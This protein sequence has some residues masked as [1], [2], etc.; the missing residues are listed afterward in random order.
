VAAGVRPALRLPGAARRYTVPVRTA[1]D[2]PTSFVG[3]VLGLGLGLLSPS[4]HAE[5]VRFHAQSGV[6]HAVSAPQ[7]DE[8]GWGAVGDIAIELPVA[9]VLGIEAKVGALWL[10]DGDGPQN[11]VFADRGASSAIDAMGG[12]RL[13]KGAT[14]P[15]ADLNAGLVRTGGVNRFGLDSHVGVDF[16][17]DDKRTWSLGPALG[18]LQVVEPD[19]S[20]RPEDARVL[21]LGVHVSFGAR[22]E[23]QVAPPPAPPPPPPPAAPAPPPPDAPPTLV[24]RDH[25]GIPDGEDACPDVPGVKTEDPHTNGCPAASAS[26]RMEGDRILLDDVIHFDLDSPRVGHVSVPL[27]KKVAEFITANASVLEIEIAGHAD[28]RGSEEHNLVLSR[29]RA[30][31]VRALLHRFGVDLARM[32]VRGFGTS[33]PRLEGHTEAEFRENRRVEFIVVRTDVRAPA[34]AP[35]T[36]GST[37]EGASR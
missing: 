14:G 22:A 10:S 21:W 27:V 18:Y 8:L 12:V 26:V 29:D 9:A 1:S 28:E 36:Q 11:P 19:D 37:P 5:P 34:T 35:A 25:D 15:W 7:K 23:K 33:K 20:L 32:T 30:L 16:D 4:A 2:F 3:S 6:A 31:A 24:D 13:Q 17:V